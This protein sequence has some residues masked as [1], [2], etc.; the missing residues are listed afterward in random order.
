[1]ESMGSETLTRILRLCVDG[2]WRIGEHHSHGVGMAWLGMAWGGSHGDGGGQCYGIAMFQPLKFETLCNVSGVSKARGPGTAAGPRATV[3]TR[4]P[5]VHYYMGFSLHLNWVGLG[6][7]R[8]ILGRPRI[9][10]LLA[11]AFNFWFWLM[12]LILWDKSEGTRRDWVREGQFLE[13]FGSKASWPRL[14][15]FWFSSNFWLWDYGS[16]GIQVGMSQGRPLSG[17]SRNFNF[18][19]WLKFLT[20]RVYV[21]GGGAGGI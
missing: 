3:A 13:S 11:L 14:F 4:V 21:G 12:F 19:F 7:G 18:W 8:P 6:H 1:M 10:G 20:L 9:Q 2:R 16:G 15:I 5:S 17:R